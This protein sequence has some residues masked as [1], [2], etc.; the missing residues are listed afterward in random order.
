MSHYFRNN[1]AFT[2]IELLVTITIVTVILTIVVL[3]QSTYT[4][5]AA[6]SNLA[7]EIGLTVS[8]AQAYGIGVKEFSPGTS[9]FSASYGLTFSLLSTGSNK[10]YLSFADRDGN[11]IYGGD[12]SCPVGGA[13]ECLSKS[14]I[15]RGNYI[16]SICIVRTAGADL[17]DVGRADIVFARPSTEDQT[18]FFNNGGQQYSPANIKGARIVLKSPH[19][20]TRSVVVYETGQIS[21]Q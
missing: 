4:D 10:A 18:V 3:N 5:T 15:S 19:G 7:D 6:L 12:W 20:S 1:R 2:L 13:S 16:E 14:D 17:C 11:Y 9:N 21:V 8:Q